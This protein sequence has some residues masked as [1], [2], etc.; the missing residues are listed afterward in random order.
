MSCPELRHQFHCPH[1]Q[2]YDHGLHWAT[3]DG[4]YGT[5]CMACYYAPRGPAWW[6][7]LE[8]VA[9]VRKLRARFPRRAMR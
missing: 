4:C 5:V 8:A 9:A 7:D 6:R 2:A 3:T 1:P